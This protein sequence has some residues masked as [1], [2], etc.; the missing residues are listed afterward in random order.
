[1]PRVDTDKSVN[2]VITEL[3]EKLL[4]EGKKTKR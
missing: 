2:E 4:S 3:L 1:M